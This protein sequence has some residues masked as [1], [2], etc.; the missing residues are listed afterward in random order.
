MPPI[1]SSADILA[2]RVQ[3]NPYGDAFRDVDMNDF[4]AMMITEL[5]NQ[6]PLNP[7]DNTQIL[8]Q[9]GQ[10]REITANDRL[11]ETL[12]A[13]FLAQNLTAATSM[14]GD[15]VVVT[16][17]DDTVLTAGQVDQVSVDNGVPRVRVGDRTLKLEQVSYIHSEAEGQELAAAMGLVGQWI[18]G[19]SDP[20]PGQLSRQVTGKVT[21]V[22]FAQGV[23]KL[24]VN[25]DPDADE[26]AEYVVDPENV[27][28]VF[29]SPP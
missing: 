8:E 24:H 18:K 11:T 17:A 22:S 21:S 28:E 29:A 10:I 7:M 16:G 3:Q 13:V 25:T 9:I 5:Q 14:I 1:S 26:G 4:L 15:W 12:E 6:D 19:A 27:A 2:S 23:P 20:L